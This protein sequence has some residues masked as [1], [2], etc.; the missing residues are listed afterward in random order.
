MLYMRRAGYD[1][2]AARDRELW[3]ERTTDTLAMIVASF[4]AVDPKRQRALAIADK[5]ASENQGEG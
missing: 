2:V 3:E 5:V 1:P 4:D